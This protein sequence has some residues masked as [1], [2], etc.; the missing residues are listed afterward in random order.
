MSV[1]DIITIFRRIVNFSDKANIINLLHLR[2]HPVPEFN[3]NHFRHIAPETVHPFSRPEK[4]DIQHLRPC[5]GNRIE[6][7]GTAVHII[8]TIIQFDRLIPIVLSGTGAEAIVTRDFAAQFAIFK[9][10]LLSSE[11]QAQGLPRYIIEII[12]GIESF[13][14]I[15]FLSQIFDIRH[16]GIRIIL[17]GNMVGYEIDDYFHSGFMRPSDQRQKNITSCFLLR[18]IFPQKFYLYIFFKTMRL[19]RKKTAS[20]IL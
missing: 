19:S 10:F 18:T 9:I 14:S 12:I 4:Q 3:R 1:P 17:A 6:M 20:P 5:I 15:V 13:R 7:R 2:D 16:L 8:N 11:L